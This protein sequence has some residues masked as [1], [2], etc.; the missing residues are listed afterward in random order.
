MAE[1]ETAIPAFI[2]YTQRAQKLAD[3][4]LDPEADQDLLASPEFEQ[5]FGVPKDDTIAVTVTKDAEWRL[6]GNGARRRR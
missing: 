6:H 5:Y 4:D 3:N 2:G 1:V